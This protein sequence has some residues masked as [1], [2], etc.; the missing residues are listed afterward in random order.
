[1]PAAV[2][3]P[4]R[5]CDRTFVPYRGYRALRYAADTRLVK[6]GAF[7]DDVARH[8]GHAALETARIYAKWSNDALPRRMAQ[9][10]SSA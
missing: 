5:L 2:G 7:L 8:L 9:W 10:Y 1:L 6:E 3:H 4:Q